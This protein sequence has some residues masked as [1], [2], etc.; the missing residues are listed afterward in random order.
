MSTGLTLVKKAKPPE[1]V[2]EPQH[3][4]VHPAEREPDEVRAPRK[5]HVERL[6]PQSTDAEKGV[7]AS[8][9]LAP[10][11]VGAMCA[12]KGVTRDHFF[13]ESYAEIFDALMYLHGERMLNGD[14]GDFIVVTQYLRDINRL[15]DCGGPAAIT[16]FYTFLPTAANCAYYVE[17]LWEKHTLRESIKFHTRQT[18]RAYTAQDEVWQMVEE[19]R[20]AVLRLA[21]STMEARGLERGVETLSLADLLD[22]NTADNPDTIIGRHWLMRGGSALWI[23]PS[24]IGKSSLALQMAV[25]FAMGLPFCGIT[26]ARPL[27]SVFMQA[28]NDL[29]DLAEMAQGVLAHIQE[30]MPEVMTPELIGKCKDN[31][32]F[33][34]DMVHV[35]QDFA[36]AV[37]RLLRKHKPDLFWAD[38]LLSYVGDDISQQAVASQFL[39]NW[40]N[41]ILAEFGVC[42]MF[43]HHTGKPPTDPGSRSHWKDS[44]ASYNSFGSSELVNWARSVNVLRP[45]GD[46]VYELH[47]AKRGKRA[48]ACDLDGQFT[49]KIYLAHAE[50]GI[51]WKQV[52]KP[53]EDE[54][55]EKKP[56]EKRES[57]QSGQ[58][59]EKFPTAYADILAM[60]AER[61]GPWDRYSLVQTAFVRVGCSSKRAYWFVSELQKKKEIVVLPDKTLA[62]AGWKP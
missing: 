60:M 13:T 18:E 15:T 27:K 51:A 16:D 34:R 17:T 11:P 43:T 30:T 1:V 32:V 49:D 12:E 53:E 20:E 45:L 55:E 40:L 5:P 38:P 59:I 36:T 3:V 14:G 50:T 26:P 19:S 25:H 61:P 47:L 22:F 39:R 28:E 31:L 4:E 48:G 46:G 8:F 62:L 10:G 57:K 41:P 54:E 9:M 21:D 2:D 29:G 56:R 6:L 42:V 7:I 24:G 52:P 44:D 33:V 58:Y 23:G 35:G 37:R